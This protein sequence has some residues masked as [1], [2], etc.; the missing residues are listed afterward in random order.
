M[1]KFCTFLIFLLLVVT[2][3]MLFVTKNKITDNAIVAESGAELKGEGAALIGGDFTL[4][5]Q[6]GIIVGD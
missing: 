1:I 4:V 6:D 5:N 3:V 2:S